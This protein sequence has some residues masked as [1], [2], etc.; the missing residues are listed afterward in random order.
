VFTSNAFAILGLR[1][2]YFLLAGAMARLSYLKLGLAAVLGF[3]G[4][5]MLVSEWFKPPILVSLGVIIGIL[6]IATIASLRRNVPVEAS[7]V[8]AESL[9]P[10]KDD[11]SLTSSK[12]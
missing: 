11:E 7:N 10:V 12:V 4:V 1:A 9:P 6:A 3:V 2:L 8:R 5:K